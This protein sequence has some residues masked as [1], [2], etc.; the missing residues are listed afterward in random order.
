MTA[1]PD[2]QQVRDI[3]YM[4]VLGELFALVVYGHLILEKA[5]MD[6]TDEDLLNQMFGV[7]VRDFSAY[8]TDL[9]GKPSNSKLQRKMI[10]QGSNMTNCVAITTNLGNFLPS[11]KGKV[12][13]T[14]KMKFGVRADAS[15]QCVGHGVP[16]AQTPMQ[17]SV[18][19]PHIHTR[20]HTH[21]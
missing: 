10:G 6:N 1:R 11:Q 4:L 15:V 12:V 21:T 20:A 8:A 17:A 14:L 9:F 18:P 13:G 16:R 7:F 3:D 19:R 2:E 5:L